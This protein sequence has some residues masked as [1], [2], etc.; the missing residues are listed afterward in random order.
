MVYD[1]SS[2]EFTKVDP[3]RLP[4]SRISMVAP[5][6]PVPDNTIGHP[7]HVELVGLSTVYPVWRRTRYLEIND[8]ALLLSMYSLNCHH[9]RIVQLDSI[10]I[11]RTQS[12]NVTPLKNEE[13]REPSALSLVI[14]FLGTPL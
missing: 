12:L 6:I 3:I 7:D 4:P 5:A 2:P 1:Q 10:T 8:V 13:S 14:L 11:V 9:T